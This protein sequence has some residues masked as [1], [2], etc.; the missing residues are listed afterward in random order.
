M[1]EELLRKLLKAVN[2]LIYLM[3]EHLN[4][5][6]NE[7]LSQQQAREYLRCSDRKLWELRKCARVIFKC[8]TG[9]KNKDY[10]YFKPSLDGLYEQF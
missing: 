4:E 5:K 3:E 8:R 7:W 1:N 10:Q 6:Q 9:K 2:K